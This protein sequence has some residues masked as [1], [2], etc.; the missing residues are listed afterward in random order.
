MFD[1]S[2]RHASYS[3]LCVQFCYGCP[4]RFSNRPCPV[5]TES[6][7]IIEQET[8]LRHRL[9][10]FQNLKSRNG[11]D[12]HIW[13]LVSQRLHELRNCGFVADLAEGPRDDHVNLSIFQER[14]EDRDGS[15]IL[16]ITE[17]VGR[18]IA[19][20]GDLRPQGPSPTGDTLTLWPIRSILQN[21]SNNLESTIVAKSRK[22]KRRIP[23]HMPI[24]IVQVGLELG[25]NSNIVE[26]HKFFGYF[27]LLPEDQ[28]GLELHSQFGGRPSLLACYEARGRQED[29][30]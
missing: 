5:K 15:C 12:T 28:V 19:I 23:S 7:L 21:R 20:A 29:E 18:V 10:G 22:H 13:I 9:F 24:F 17:E 25:K 30:S 16:Q 14:Y 8:Q 1:R 6:L 4:S 27:K 11:K 26:L 3:R 2:F